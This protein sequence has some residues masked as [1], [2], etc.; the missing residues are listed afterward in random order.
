MYTCH[1][2]LGSDQADDLRITRKQQE[3]SHG[4][5]TLITTNAAPLQRQLSPC[6]SEENFLW[7]SGWYRDL[8]REA[9][10]KTET[11]T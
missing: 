1:N 2:Y 5:F 10:T 3:N 9:D 4:G 6:G 11:E 7:T 8:N